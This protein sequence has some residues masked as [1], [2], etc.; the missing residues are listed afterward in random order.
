M[1]T[2]TP[3][4]IMS[5]TEDL[6]PKTAVLHQFTGIGDLIWHLQYIKAVAAQSRDGQ[7]SLIAQPS[8]FARQIVG[9]EPWI[10]SVIDHDHRP[11]R[12]AHKKRAEHGGLSGMRRMARSLRALGFERIVLFSG[13][14]S[15]GLLAAL[16]GIPVR[17]GYGYYPLQRCFLNCPPYISRYRG[18]SVAA[19]KE[20][21]A[22]AIAHG[23]CEAPLIPRLDIPSD[24]AKAMALRLSDMPRPL[25]AL[26]IG[27]SEPHKQWG[28]EKFAALAERLAA[29]GAGVI[30][31][32]GPAEAALAQEIH[33][34]IAEKYGAQVV[35]LTNLRILE[36]AAVLQS[37]DVCTGNDT[38][39]INIAAAVGT[40]TLVLL[41]QRP[42]LDHDPL[43]KSLTAPSL[44][45]LSVD[46]VWSELTPWMAAAKPAIAHV[47]TL[48]N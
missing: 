30:L 12:G 35:S 40:P 23:F 1:A 34:A 15:R 41:G 39:M 16:S 43:L 19:I 47:S 4:R 37:A 45:A 13:R 6:R 21:G 44:K 17:M 7:V 25:H 10:A 27:T 32:G 22:F 14:V 36:S 28:L 3:C 33:A 9:H 46:A 2:Y 26:V 38:G 5:P 18:R 42:V 24:V 20:A 8:T 29:T 31:L 11:R 48:S